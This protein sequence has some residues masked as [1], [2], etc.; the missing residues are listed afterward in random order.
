[1]IH[2]TYNDKKYAPLKVADVCDYLSANGW[3]KTEEKQ[4]VWTLWEKDDIEILCPMS[5]TLN[6]YARRMCEVVY[7]LS[8]AEQ[9]SEEEVLA[10]LLRSGP[11][12]P[13]FASKE[14]RMEAILALAGSCPDFPTI[15]EI[16]CPW[17]RKN[18]VLKI[19]IWLTFDLQNGSDYRG[20]YTWLSEMDAKDCGDNAA[21]MLFPCRKEPKNI[22]KEILKSIKG[23]CKLT[24]HDRI[25]V[26]YHRYRN[27][28][29]IGTFINGKQDKNPPWK[30]YRPIDELQEGDE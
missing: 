28:E 3:Q 13:H 26:I 10:D 16:R 20:F 24:K 18:G 5:S 12:K 23:R 6:D 11:K 4:N 29:T 21:T 22:L 30:G 14:E 8:I 17:M 15:E 2:I 9:R 27:G 25:Y 1:M 7:N 19:P